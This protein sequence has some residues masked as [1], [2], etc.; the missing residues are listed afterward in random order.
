MI[1]IT[2]CDLASLS[3]ACAVCVRACVCAQVCERV[4]VCA[5]ASVCVCTS[6]L[7]LP[8]PDED[9]SR[10]REDDRK[11]RVRAQRAGLALS[12][13]LMRCGTGG[14]PHARAHPRA[15]AHT[16]LHAQTVA[17]V[18]QVGFHSDEQLVI[19]TATGM[20]IDVRIPS[21]VRERVLVSV[22]ARAC[23]WLCTGPEPAC[24]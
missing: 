20:A 18:T 6:R 7:S 24:L 23:L 19:Q 15:C 1:A 16:Q 21:R 8:L 4:C 14:H 3:G 22:L 17:L 2:L 5:R 11:D 10:A 13:T 9:V 12:H